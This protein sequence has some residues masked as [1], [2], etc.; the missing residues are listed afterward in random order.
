MLVIVEQC[1]DA[2]PSVSRVLVIRVRVC[3]RM[4]DAVAMAL[5]V[6][7]RN[8]FVRVGVEHSTGMFVFVDV[9]AGRL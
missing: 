6:F 8:V 4:K 5:L 2:L 9:V 1:L 3:V 7:V